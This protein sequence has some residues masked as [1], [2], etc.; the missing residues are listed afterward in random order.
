[1]FSQIFFILVNLL[2]ELD[3]FLF[4]SSCSFKFVITS[5]FPTF[6]EFLIEFNVICLANSNDF[7]IFLFFTIE[8]NVAAE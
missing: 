4:I 5:P 1:M 8:Y 2:I 7:L 6:F 3:N